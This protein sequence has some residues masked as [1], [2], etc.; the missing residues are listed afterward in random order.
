[1]VR[2]VSA[3]GYV[4]C[5]LS[6]AYANP[7][8]P[9]ARQVLPTPEQFLRAY[10][11]VWQVGGPNRRYSSEA[12]WRKENPDCLEQSRQLTLGLRQIPDGEWAAMKAQLKEQLKMV[13]GIG[14][15]LERSGHVLL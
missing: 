2:L 10:K 11:P 14:F 4:L 12:D 6:V 3:L 1:M 13:H 7:P 5:G 9:S 15:S 8:L